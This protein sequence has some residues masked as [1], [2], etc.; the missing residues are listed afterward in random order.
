MPCRPRSIS[1]A[2][3]G[4]SGIAVSVRLLRAATEHGIRVVGIIVS[5]NAYV[6]ARH[7]LGL[8]VEDFKSLLS[9]YS[10]VYG[11]EDYESPLASSSSQPDA[12][13]IVPASMKTVSQIAAGIQD[14]LIVRAALSI[15]RLGRPLV[16]APRET[17]L[18][19]AELQAL[20]KVAHMGVKVVPLCP[21]YY[22]KP[23]SLNDLV[24]FMVGKIL[25]V[26]GVD[27]DLY[28]RW[29]LQEG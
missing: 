11:E 28:R 26:L 17:P 29:G 3:T 21:G 12:M 10:R 16:V 25:D 22:H 15:L 4:A 20:L 6:V 19:I 1:V 27:N 14:N 8:S 13:V 7:E 23:R 2:I 18:G 5:R 9:Q 24:D